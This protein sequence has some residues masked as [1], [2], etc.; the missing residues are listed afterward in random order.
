LNGVLQV[1]ERGDASAARTALKALPS[2]WIPLLGAAGAARDPVRVLREFLQESRR[3][4]ELRRQWWRTLA[5][6]L[7][8]GGIAVAV[9]VALSIF[10]IP[11]FRDIF[12]SFGLKLPGFTQFVF[13]VAEWITSGRLLIAAIGLIGA[14]ILLRAVARLL[15]QAVREWFGDRFG[16]LLGR[17]TALARF[18]QFL[19]DLLEAEFDIPTALRIAGFATD[20]PRIRRAAR[21]LASDLAAG[22]GMTLH[23][24]RPFLSATVIHVLRA[25]LPTG[26]RVRLLAEISSCHADRGSRHLSWTH[27]VVQ[28][29]AICVVAL[30]VGATVIALFLPLISLIQGLS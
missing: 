25:D 29:L 28:P 16:T 13:A 27:G 5:Y 2:Y 24:Y 23:A 11:I 6:P 4:D 20:S 14:V 22:G 19:A 9:M 1:L 12:T 10:V 7:F 30:V 26:S 18:S 15:P 21:R 3:A 8:V 17:S